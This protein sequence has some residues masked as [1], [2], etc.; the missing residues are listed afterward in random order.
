[1]QPRSA[2]L[3]HSRP[4]A[5]TRTNVA[6]RSGS[7]RA[8]NGA[9]ATFRGLLHFTGTLA[10]VGSAPA[11]KA[12]PKPATPVQLFLISSSVKTEIKGPSNLIPGLHLK[13]SLYFTF[14]PVADIRVAGRCRTDS[15]AALE[16]GSPRRPF[17]RLV[18][19]F[20]SASFASGAD[21]K[22]HIRAGWLNVGPRPFGWLAGASALA[23]SLLSQCSLS[24]M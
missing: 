7:P 5:P 15:W 3:P 21:W 9:E 1:M 24:G 17:A 23:P 18:P 2:R 19:S 11:S 12:R 22:L 14:L 16:A 10:L 6:M 20:T 8:G 4:F 13:S